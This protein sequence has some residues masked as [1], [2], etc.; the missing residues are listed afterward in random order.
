MIETLSQVPSA[1]GNLDD[2]YLTKYHINLNCQAQHC[3]HSPQRRAHRV[4]YLLSTENSTHSF[5]LIK[6][7]HDVLDLHDEQSARWSSIHVL[8]SDIRKL[9]I[10]AVQTID[11]IIAL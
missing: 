2:V 3:E 6:Y 5:R 11:C 10:L 8:V 1:H 9:P 4:L 7:L